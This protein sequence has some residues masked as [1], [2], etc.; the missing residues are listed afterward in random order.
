[1]K[2]VDEAIIEVMA[3]K[4]GDG[5]SSF[6]REKFV[7]FGGPNGGD[8]GEGGSIYFVADPDL[9]TLIDFRYKRIFK[10]NK[11]QGGLGS[12]CSGKSGDDLFIPVPCGT[13]VYSHDT[14]E[15]LGDLLNAGD[16]LLVAKGGARGLGNARFKTSTNRS[17]QKFTKGKLGEIRKLRLVMNVL[18]DVGLLGLPNAGKSTFI[19]SV[20]AAKP[21]IADY[22]FTTLYP[23]LGTIRLG[24]GRSFVIADIP[25][26]IEGASQG[27]G[28]GHKFLKHLQRT[29]VLLHIVDVYSPTYLNDIKIII[30]ELALYSEQYD[31]DLIKKP[32]WLVLNKC[33]LM[34][35]DQI[36]EIVEQIKSELNLQQ[37]VFCVSAVTRYHTTELVNKLG[38]YIYHEEDL[39]FI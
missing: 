25:G 19:S 24:E 15:C 5:C 2:F 7:P 32:R 1:M 23:N 4:G 37:E 34:S 21:K 9:N 10:A 18:A 35:A 6:R 30:N 27:T 8:G 17:P 31:V 39:D 29:K 11:G 33:D 28:L 12:D 13:K 36:F 14:E 20:S 26:L 16:K 3:G 38:E 22:P